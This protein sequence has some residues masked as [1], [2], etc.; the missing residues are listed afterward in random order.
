MNACEDHTESHGVMRQP[1]SAL[2]PA[3]ASRLY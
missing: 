1:I 2:Y 3:P